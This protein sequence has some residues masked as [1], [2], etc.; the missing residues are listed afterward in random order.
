[1]GSYRQ[2]L[3]AAGVPRLVAAATFARLPTSMLELCLLIGLVQVTGYAEAGF[4]LTAHAVLLATGAPIAGRLVDRLGARP[5]VGGYVVL[6]AAGYIGLLVALDQRAS[7]SFLAT[8]AG[9]VGFSTPPTN[10]AIRSLWAEWFDGDRLRSA[11]A[12][13]SALNSASFVGGPLIAAGVMVATSPLLATLATGIVRLTGDLLL[14]TRR[15]T[16]TGARSVSEAA[17]RWRLGPLAHPV[18]RLMLCVIA[19]DT[20]I[21][22]YLVI[23]AAASTGGESTTGLLTGALSAGEVAG[24]LIYGARR[25]PGSLRRQLMI[26]H[27]A[28]AIVLLLTGLVA[29][30]PL[31][32][33]GFLAAGTVS[34][35]RDALNNLALSHITTAAMR[36]ETFAWLTTFMWAGFGL[37]T[38][39]AGQLKTQ[40]NTLAVYLVA[41][42]LG[43]LAA[44]LASRII[45]PAVA[46]SKPIAD[47]QPTPHHRSGAGPQHRPEPDPATAP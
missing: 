28:T 10:A 3:S 2:F 15:D 7:L 5:V 47:P 4:V 45:R 37:G 40:A 31:L 17:N 27:L 21:H 13:D 36:T 9:V 19:L 8:A 39:T 12:F 11:Y 42:G 16:D 43:L 32:V 30:L 6:H 14:I 29:L 33:L 24:G 41:A 38:A 26:L 20:C 22:G 25:W 34:G 44:A 46:R 18:L 23:A 35:A 1:M